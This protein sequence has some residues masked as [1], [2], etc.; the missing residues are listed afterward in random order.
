MAAVSSAQSIHIGAG[1]SIYPMTS[2]TL[3]AN[4]IDRY[5]STRGLRFLR[6]DH[7]GEYFCVVNPHLGR[8][9]VHL[10]MSPSFGDMLMINV[11]PARFF[12]SPTARG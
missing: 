10:Q 3:C 5:L 6:G 8:L 2:E 11:S 9:H 4:L 1:L 12:P 7:D